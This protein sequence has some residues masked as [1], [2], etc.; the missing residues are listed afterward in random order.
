MSILV[1]KILY[2]LFMLIIISLISFI[3]INLAPHSFLGGGELNPNI[4]P[5][6][7]KKLED[8]YGLNRP[9]YE[10][11]IR[12]LT[13]IFTLDFGVSFV[14]GARVSE[15]ILKRLPVTLIINLSA[16]FSVFVISMY[17][18][19]KSALKGG[20]FEESVKRV[21]LISFAMPSFYLA[22]L[23]VLLFSYYA[24]L[25]PISGL[26]S[27]GI[28]EGGLYYYIDSAWHLFLPVF[29]MVFGGFGS[30]T[31]YI[32]SLTYEIKKSDYYFFAKARGLDEK[33]ILRY[34][35]IPNLYPPII[36]ML[37]LSLPGLIGG[38]VIL[39]TIFAIDGM[40]LLFYNAALSR[41]YPVIM[42]ILIIGA[43]LTLLGNI[44][45][46]I[47]LLSLNPYFKK[48]KRN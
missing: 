43:F 29:V 17:L 18:G 25:F 36:T 16:M 30:L 27:Q 8:I 3:A 45:A 1:N 12:W 42:G 5:E 32:R 33:T 23:L 39:E 11:Y 22:I 37:G 34:Y 10:Q 9:L 24:S 6:S 2:T 40:G 44:L 21:S 46:D 7:M 26:H 28:K 13:A 48:G 41:D 19:I 31:L 20:V 38:S 4:T 14:S 35:I 47:T 15:E